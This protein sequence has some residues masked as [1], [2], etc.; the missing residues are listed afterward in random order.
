MLA[1][2][3]YD[4]YRAA[5]RKAESDALAAAGLLEARLVTTLRRVQGDLEHLVE[6][7]PADA[8]KSGATARFREQIVQNWICTCVALPR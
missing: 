6:S 1:F 3:L 5:E 8:F 7:L 2:L 4:G